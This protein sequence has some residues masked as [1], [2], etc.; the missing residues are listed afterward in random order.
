MYDL[1]VRALHIHHLASS[2]NFQPLTLNLK[3]SLQQALHQCANA[4]FS[5]V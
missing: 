4:T 2:I 1:I 3:L 5:D